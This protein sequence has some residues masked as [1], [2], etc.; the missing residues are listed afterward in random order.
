M[1]IGDAVAV[2]CRGRSASSPAS[3]VFAAACRGS[4]AAWQRAR[5]TKRKRSR[6]GRP[7]SAIGTTRRNPG[8]RAAP[9]RRPQELRHH[10]DH[11]RR[12]AR[13]RDGRAARDH[14]PQ[15]RRQV[16]A[17]QSRQRPLRADARLDPAPRR[18]E[19]AGRRPTGSTAAGS[20]AASRS[21]TSS[22]ASS[23]TRTSAAASSGRW[24][25][26]ISF[27]RDVDK[28]AAANARAGRRAG[29]DRHD[30][31]PRHAGRR[32]DLRRAAR[33]RDR[34]HDRRRAPA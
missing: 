12:F 4:R 34:H 11:S 26:A 21:P 23:C 22:R 16:H 31:P 25:T 10:A 15:R 33:A 7:M 28:L 17:V 19:I 29:A 32:A 20:R 2:A 5:P 18:V 8:L 13:H 9:R 14:R 24:A 27:W 1:D 30:R 6:G 3:S